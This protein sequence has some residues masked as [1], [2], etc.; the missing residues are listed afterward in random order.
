M[1]G[2]VYEIRNRVNGKFYIGS[3][4]N[5]KARWARHLSALC[6]GKHHNSHLQS[7]FDKYGEA[8]FAFSVLESIEPQNLIE[9]EQYHLD[10]FHPEYNIA[11]IAGS[12]LGCRH[13]EQTK[14]K[15]S[16]G[17]MGHPVSEEARAK[18]S[19]A[20][21]PDRRRKCSVAM[22]GKRNPMYGKYPDAEMRAKLS[23][24]HTGHPVSAETRAKLSK[25]LSGERNP[26]YGV[27][28]NRHPMYGKSHTEEA[29]KKMSEAMSGERHPN[30]GKHHSEETRRKMSQAR[31]AYWRRIHAT[32]VK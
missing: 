7:A 29:R 19:A 9:R 14:Q 17:K 31:K 8:A 3:A 10:M 21:T 24:A 4:A 18:M 25:A 26:M 22:R 27:S 11:R 6:S 13:T 20:W 16:A 12:N 1:N 28:G 5:L 30:F 32:E 15:I 2:G 23:A